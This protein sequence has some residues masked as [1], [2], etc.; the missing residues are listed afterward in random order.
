MPQV[1]LVLRVTELGAVMMSDVP[2]LRVGGR[3]GCV[4]RIES[5]CVKSRERKYKW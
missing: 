2:G 1:E 4:G 5:R 3:G